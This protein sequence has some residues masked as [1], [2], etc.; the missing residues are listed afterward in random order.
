MNTDD[1]Y[2][3][4]MKLSAA[5]QRTVGEGDIL[6]WAAVLPDWIEVC[7]ALEGIAIYYRRSR[8]RIMPVDLIQASKEARAKRLGYMLQENL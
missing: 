8:E 5:D 1:S 6:W 4:L 3:V 7:D 2:T